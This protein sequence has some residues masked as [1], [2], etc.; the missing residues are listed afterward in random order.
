MDLGGEARGERGHD[1]R[2]IEALI[3]AART[4][5]DAS[6]DPKQAYD[7]FNTALNLDP[8]RLELHVEM[9][10]LEVRC[11]DLDRAQERMAL[12]AECYVRRFGDA[13]DEKA[14]RA[15]ESI[16]PPPPAWRDAKSVPH[17]GRPST[18]YS[19]PNLRARSRIWRDPAT[20]DRSKPLAERLRKLGGFPKK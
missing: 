5:A 12:V 2:A 11:G 4:L 17:G 3:N 6:V 7:L 14:P 15:E 1:K 10:E 18:R 9:A 16:V 20:S 19:I 13:S 8:Q